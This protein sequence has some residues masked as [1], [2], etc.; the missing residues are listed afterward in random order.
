LTFEIMFELTF[1]WW[2][3]LFT[4]KHGSCGVP[5]TNTLA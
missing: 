3:R 1:W 5:V 2:T 4:V